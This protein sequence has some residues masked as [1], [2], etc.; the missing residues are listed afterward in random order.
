MKH[1]SK[2]QKALYDIIAP[3]VEFQIHCVAY[4]IRSKIGWGHESAPRVWITI[5][6]EIVLDFPRCCP[7]KQLD[8]MYYPYCGDL[9]F[10]SQ[11]LRDYIDCPQSGLMAFHNEDKHWGLIPALRACERRIGKRRLQEM[12]TDNSIVREIIDSRMCRKTTL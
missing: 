11:T 1:W 4:P 8:A 3:E 5:G 2:L 9:S 10:I 6:K 7:K 12:Q